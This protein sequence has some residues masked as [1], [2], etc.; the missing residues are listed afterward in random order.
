MATFWTWAVRN[1]FAVVAALGLAAGFTEVLE[2]SASLMLTM[3]AAVIADTAQH[4]G[5]KARKR[6]ARARA[7]SEAL[8]AAVALRKRLTEGDSKELRKAA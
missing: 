6:A 4:L 8:D 1:P 3:V 7:A 2:W 5:A